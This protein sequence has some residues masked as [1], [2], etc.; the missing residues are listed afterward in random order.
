MR[1]YNNSQWLGINRR[2]S[3]AAEPLYLIGEDVIPLS[4]KTIT[5]SNISSKY[6]LAI[7]LS[8]NKPVDIKERVELNSSKSINICDR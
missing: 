3:S 6:H 7:K 5:F 1:L 2:N 8:L 4:C